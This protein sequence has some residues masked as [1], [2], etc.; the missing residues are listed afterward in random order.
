MS[1]VRRVW[2]IAGA[3]LAL[4]VAQLALAQPTGNPKGSS[5]P[6]AQGNSTKP[7]AT[8]PSPVDSGAGPIGS[9][10]GPSEARTPRTEPPGGGTAGGLTHRKLNEND[11]DAKSRTNKGSAAPRP[12]PS[13]S[14]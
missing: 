1:A 13:G 5:A 6:S 10:Q 4:T 14:R 11:P 8:R 9:D 2:R 7:G 3:A 12:V